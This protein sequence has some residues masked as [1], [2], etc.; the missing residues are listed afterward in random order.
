MGEGKKYPKYDSRKR[1]Q[2]AALVRNTHKINNF[3]R[4][5]LVLDGA[6][7]G[8]FAGFITLV[9][10]FVLS[11]LEVLRSMFLTQNEMWIWG[12]WGV[13]LLIMGGVCALLL[14]WAPLSGGSGIPQVQGE[15]FGYFKMRP[16]RV[17]ISKFIGGGLGNFAGLSL[18][19][20]GPSI[21]IGACCGKIISQKLRR[22]IREEKL[23]LAAGAAAGLS[24]AFGA[25]IAGTIFVLEEIYKQFHPLA[26]VPAMIA[27]IVAD[28]LGKYVFGLN[29]IFA[30]ADHMRYALPL[31]YYY[32]VLLLGALMG[33]FGVMF[34]K[35]LLK[36]QDFYKNSPLPKKYYPLPAFLAAGVGAIFLPAVLGGGHTMIEQANTLPVPLYFLLVILIVKLIFTWVCYGS[37]V[38]GGIFLPLLAI[39]GLVGIIYARLTGAGGMLPQIYQTHFTII[40]MAGMLTAVVRS[41]ILSVILMTEMTGSFMNVLPIGLISIVAYIIAQTLKCP[42][43]YDALLSKML[44]KK[45]EYVSE[46]QEKR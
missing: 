6:L 25:P 1:F 3:V 16:W 35:G 43:V 40:A 17:L 39:G 4:L 9:Y 21:Q 2:K 38:Q 31:R 7:V 8:I 14:R 28:F 42:P 29:P 30:F 23:L 13:G 15:I 32:L 33:L 41:P 18:G 24:A 10:R 20:E 5:R 34:Y 37:G 45:E 26:M 12:V 11:K 36:F 22:G 27:A 19:R 44:G 46:M